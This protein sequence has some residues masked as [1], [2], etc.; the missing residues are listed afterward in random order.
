MSFSRAAIVSIM[1]GVGKYGLQGM[2]K[3]TGPVPSP[4]SRVS[5][6]IDGLWAPLRNN[7]VTL[8]AIEPPYEAG[9]MGTFGPVVLGGP[10]GGARAAI[11]YGYGGGAVQSV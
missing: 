3:S 7:E 5:A 6:A 1:A 4:P 11:Q 9:P 10:R 8:P 2:Q